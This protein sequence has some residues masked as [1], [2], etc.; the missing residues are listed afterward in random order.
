MDEKISQ[1][2]DSEKDQ[3]P[4]S[5]LQNKT[6]SKKQKQN[7]LP[8]VN[9]S[10]SNSKTSQKSFIS[11]VDQLSALIDL[12][13]VT[14]KTL[15]EVVKKYHML[16]TPY[17]FS[18]IKD[19]NNENDPIRKQCVPAIEELFEGP[20]DKID[21]LGEKETSVTSLLVHRYPDRALL[22]VTSRCFMY[23]RHCTRKRLWKAN[24]VEPNLMEIKTALDYVRSTKAIRELIIS[25]GDPLTL[26]PERLDWILTEVSSIPHIEVIRIGTRTPVVFPERINRTLCKILGAYNNLWVN[27]QFN[28]PDE[29]T[30]EAA[31]A[32][33]KLQKCGIPVSN[34][35]VLLKGIN[36]SVEVM[37]ELCHK[38]QA[39]RP[40]R[41][42]DN[43]DSMRKKKISPWN[44][45]NEFVS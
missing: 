15:N 36:D 8:P 24:N 14:Q 2:N 42:F 28:H 10:S 20:S 19:A 26:S 17:Y 4:D 34:Q 7:N 32:C 38:L 31:E 16:I 1:C 25:G 27:V 3:P 11:S 12:D 30:P 5:G 22:I 6:V 13:K 33:R 43:Y 40:Y 21:P 44:Y 41:I 18:L 9:I 39:I 23:C 45:F 37:K 29:I 35:S